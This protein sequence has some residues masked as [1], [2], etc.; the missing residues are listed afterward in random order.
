MP[1]PHAEASELMAMA[2]MQVR[3]VRMAV[4]QRRV[5]VGMR[6]RLGPFVAAMRMLVMLVVHVPVLV[7]HRLVLVLVTVALAQDEPG[8]Y[9]G[10]REGGGHDAA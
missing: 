1:S 4:A 8:S 5:A 9:S 2:V 10:K 6:V 7:L 3:K